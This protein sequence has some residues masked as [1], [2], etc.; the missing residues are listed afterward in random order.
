MRINEIRLGAP[1]S[2]S[3][4]ELEATILQDGP[5]FWA[6]SHDRKWGCVGLVVEEIIEGKLCIN[7]T[8][9]IDNVYERVIAAGD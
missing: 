8:L 3:W 2:L 6:I 5:Y 9:Y 7:P 4:D 1:V